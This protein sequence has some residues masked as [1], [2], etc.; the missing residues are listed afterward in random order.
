[1]IRNCVRFLCVIFLLTLAVDGYTQSKTTPKAKSAAPAKKT[2]KPVEK[3]EAVEDEAPPEVEKLEKTVIP[4]LPP[5]P[6]IDTTAAP[7]DDLT[8]EIKLMLNGSGAMKATVETMKAMLDMQRKN[9][10]SALPV[11]FYDRFLQTIENGRVSRLL[12]NAIVKVYR[13]KFTLQEMK[14]VNAFYASATGKKMAAEQSALTAAGRVAG[15]NLGK[16][17]ALQILGDMMKEGKLK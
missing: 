2:A 13:E 8:K 3:K 14:D 1:M 10:S 5:L 7:D 4:S 17:I 9:P 15:E 12:E 6:E 11:E 16:F